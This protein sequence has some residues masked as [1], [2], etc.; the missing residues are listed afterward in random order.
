MLNSSLLSSH[1]LLLFAPILRMRSLQLLAHAP[2]VSMLTGAKA[3]EGVRVVYI[4]T[5]FLF[6]CVVS[7]LKF[8]IIAR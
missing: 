3:Y 7:A 6:F 8:I 2:S 1:G 5:T 4:I